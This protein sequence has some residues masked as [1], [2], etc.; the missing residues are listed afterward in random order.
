MPGRE[1]R[2][3]RDDV[4]VGIGVGGRQ[5]FQV[6]GRGADPASVAD[7][8]SRGGRRQVLAADVHARQRV[9]RRQVGSIVDPE[10]DPGREPLERALDRA[11]ELGV[12]G[13]L[14]PDL[15]PLDPAGGHGRHRLRHA[16]ESQHVGVGDGVER[17]DAIASQ[18]HG[19]GWIVNDPPWNGNA[20]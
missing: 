6:V 9:E 5:L 12:G 10:R 15:D 1:D 18:A 4:D 17:G 14:G 13:A 7:H 3:Q 2:A 11:R 8:G 19:H 20:P 16:L